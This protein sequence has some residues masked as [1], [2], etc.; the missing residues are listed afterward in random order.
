MRALDILAT[1]IAAE[2]FP[3]A[4]VISVRRWNKLSQQVRDSSE[5]RIAYELMRGG[6]EAFVLNGCVIFKGNVSK[7]KVLY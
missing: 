1:Q 4:A 6:I 3:K 2:K 5:Q 7:F